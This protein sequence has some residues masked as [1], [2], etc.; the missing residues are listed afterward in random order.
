M[1]RVMLRMQ[2][3]ALIHEWW[4]RI[5]DWCS[6]NNGQVNNHD[7]DG[8]NK[9]QSCWESTI[10]AR[11]NRILDPGWFDRWWSHGFMIHPY[12]T[13]QYLITWFW[14][15]HS[16][17]VSRHFK[18]MRYILLHWIPIS[19]LAVSNYYM[20]IHLHGVYIISTLLLRFELWVKNLCNNWMVE[21]ETFLWTKM[22]YYSS[23]FG[24]IIYLDYGTNIHISKY[25][26]IG[27]LYVFK[28]YIIQNGTFEFNKGKKKE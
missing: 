3:H 2:M 15:I 13:W 14:F 17:R 26:F 28:W 11:Y 10:P 9:W 16:C 7:V 8:V 21:R 18:P 6:S 25:C 19:T 24:W 1:E 27:L 20:W 12:P 5:G 23:F 4:Y 22:I